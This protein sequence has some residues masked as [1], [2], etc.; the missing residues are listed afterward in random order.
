MLRLTKNKRKRGT[1]AS[2][3]N[4]T[5]SDWAVSPLP[6]ST[7]YTQKLKA[8]LLGREWKFQLG[9]LTDFGL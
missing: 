3:Q 5:F 7:Q 2:L 1:K 6:I 8:S 9:W 4:G